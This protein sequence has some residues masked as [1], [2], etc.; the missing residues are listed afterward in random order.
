MRFIICLIIGLFFIK[1]TLSKELLYSDEYIIDFVSENITQIKEE[2]IYEIKYDSFKKII[3]SLLTNDE[4]TKLNKIIDINFINRFVYGIDISEEKINNNTYFSK[5]KIAYD[6]SKIIDFFISNN[7]DFIAYEPEPYLIVIFDQRIFSEK[8]LS[9]ENK[10]YKFLDNNKLKYEFFSIPNL[11]I[12][13]RFIVQKEDFFYK[14]ISNY[15]KLFNKY[16]NVNILLVHSIFKNNEFN[17]Y[18]YIYEDNYFYSLDSFYYKKIDYEKFFYDLQIKTLDYWKNKNIVNSSKLNQL[19]CK[20]KTLN[21][22]ELKTIKKIIDN[23]KIIKIIKANEI[24]YNS[25]IYDLL[26]YGN[27][28][29]L[30]K[31]LNKDKIHLKIN[32]NLCEIKII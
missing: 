23:N 7:L 26:Y 31:S 30:I 1:P 28:N 12:N 32:D 2:K 17:I 9:P 13:D 19:E 25:S 4:Y 29:I 14:K 18:S 21:L 16:K 10:Y 3:I 27:L 24:S 8:I 5:I 15:D 6:N 11:D 20:V 22:V